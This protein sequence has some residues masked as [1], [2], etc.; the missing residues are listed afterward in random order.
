MVFVG[1]CNE[2]RGFWGFFQLYPLGIPLTD[3][4]VH[5]NYLMLC[6]KSRFPYLLQSVVKGCPRNSVFLTPRLDSL[7]TCQKLPVHICNCQEKWILTILYLQK[8]KL[9]RANRLSEYRKPS[10]GGAAYMGFSIFFFL[11]F[12]FVVTVT[13]SDFFIVVHF[14]ST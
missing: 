11:Y 9:R 4:C 8:H 13:I 14:P 5:R 3:F 1:D 12:F 2:I 7:S 6:F 10:P